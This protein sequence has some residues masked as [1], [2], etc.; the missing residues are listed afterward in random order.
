MARFNV[1]YRF[2]GTAGKTIEATSLEAA[3]AMVEAEVE[4][5]DFELEADDI[6][7]VKFYVQ[8]LHPVTRDGR[9]IWTTYIHTNDVRGH[10]SALATSPLFSGVPQQEAAGELA[11]GGT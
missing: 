9:E 7:D 6:D 3:E 1:S 2:Q 11:V 8:E 5:D 4:R 10:Q